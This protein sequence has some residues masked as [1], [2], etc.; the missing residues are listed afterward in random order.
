[1]PP[2]ARPPTTSYWPPTSA[3]GCSFGSKS[4]G[5]RHFGQNPFDRPGTPSRDRPTGA[6]QTEQKRLS[7]ATVGGSI[8]AWRGSVTGT[9]GTWVRP[10]PRRDVCVVAVSRRVGR[11]APLDRAD[12]RGTRPRRVVP[13]VVTALG[14]SPS[15]CDEA[16]EAE[17]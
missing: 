17:L 14:G 11:L 7:S 4:N 2:W 13:E 9:D 10:A 6:P 1:M 15:A 16:C 8:K 3:P 5:V 12:P